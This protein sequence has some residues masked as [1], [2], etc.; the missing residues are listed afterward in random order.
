MAHEEPRAVVKRLA[1]VVAI[2]WA[3]TTALGWMMAYAASPL[4]PFVILALVSAVLLPPTMI[5]LAVQRLSGR[6]LQSVYAVAL[7]AAVSV[8]WFVTILGIAGAAGIDVPDPPLS[9]GQIVFAIM[10]YGGGLTIITTLFV[11]P[12]RQT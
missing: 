5:W 6:R 12:R 2:A 8:G 7:A 1:T 4:I 11:R 10:F 9:V 3:L